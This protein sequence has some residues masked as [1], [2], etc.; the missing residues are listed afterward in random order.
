MKKAIAILLVAVIAMTFV[1]C[2][3]GKDKGNMDNNSATSSNNNT[4]G[5]NGTNNSANNGNNGNNNNSDNNNRNTTRA[6]EN[7]LESMIPDI[8][9]NV[10]TEGQR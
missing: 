1:A 3:M 6:T 5:T 10:N 2:N 9:T 8:S 4:G 7:I